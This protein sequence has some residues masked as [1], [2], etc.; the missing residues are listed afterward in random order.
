MIYFQREKPN[1]LPLDI[2]K[3]WE[4]PSREISR[5]SLTFTSKLY[6]G[7]TPHLCSSLTA[8]GPLPTP[9]RLIYKH[10][11]PLTPYICEQHISLSIEL[12]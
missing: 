12:C 2:N 1:T 7:G 10:G 5:S 4:I 6:L 9:K 3:H 11:T 8:I